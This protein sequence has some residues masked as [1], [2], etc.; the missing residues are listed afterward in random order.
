MDDFACL[1]YNVRRNCNT[2]K[3]GEIDAEGLFGEL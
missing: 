2:Q 3:R 1:Q